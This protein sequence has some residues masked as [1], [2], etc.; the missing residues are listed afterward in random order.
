MWSPSFY[1]KVYMYINAT[2]ACAVWDNFVQLS[3]THAYNRTTTNAVF[4]N[5][6]LQI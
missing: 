1:P 5:K 3:F 6:L 2:R 4:V